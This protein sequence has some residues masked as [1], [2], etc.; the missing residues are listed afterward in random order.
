M[1]STASRPAQYLCCQSFPKNIIGGRG[2]WSMSVWCSKKNNECCCIGRTIP[3]SVS[4]NNNK[5]QTPK[6]EAQAYSVNKQNNKSVYSKP[7]MMLYQLLSPK[8][9]LGCHML[10]KTEKWL[11]VKQR[12][13]YCL[14]TFSWPDATRHWNLEKTGNIRPNLVTKQVSN[15][16]LGNNLRSS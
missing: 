1:L 12:A 16:R 9:V 7:Y 10:V 13:F 11:S 6:D 14:P 3:M 2:L 8:L 15:T 4:E 5:N